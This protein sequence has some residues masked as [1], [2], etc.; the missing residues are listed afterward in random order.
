MEDGKQAAKRRLAEAL[1]ANLKRR[2]SVAR[3]QPKRET[4]APATAERDDRG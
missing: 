2:K 4:V 1:R 3:A